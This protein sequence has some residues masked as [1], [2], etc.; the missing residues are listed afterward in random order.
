[1]LE[2]IAV[3]FAFLFALGLSALLLTLPKF[4]A[5]NLPS[6]IKSRPFECGKEPFALPGGNMPVHFYIVAMLF[7]IFDVE[8]VFLFPWA[9]LFRKLG[10]FGLAEMAVFLGFVVLGFLY[11]LKKRALAWE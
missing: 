5:P 3:I 4:L 1:M 9:V 6:D 8:M 10:I 11:V 2:Y 7:I